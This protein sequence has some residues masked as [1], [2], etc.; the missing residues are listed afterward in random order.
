MACKLLFGSH[1]S[2]SLGSSVLFLKRAC[3]IGGANFF[4][5][6]VV[7]ILYLSHH[8]RLGILVPQPGTELRSSAS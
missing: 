3:E 4:L 6:N 1:S 2:L 8:T 7:D 5:I